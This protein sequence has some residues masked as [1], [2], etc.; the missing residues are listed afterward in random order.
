MLLKI[1]STGDKLHYFQKSLV[2]N[3][4]GPRKVLSTSA[5][6]GG[7]SE[8]LETVFNHD[9]NPGA[10]MACLMK[11]PTYE[12]HIKLL[13]LELGLDP[14]ES[15]GLETAASMDNVSIVQ[16]K[17]SS[18][19]V[20]AL[21]TGGVEVNGGRVGDPVCEEGYSLGTINIILLIDANLPSYTLTR[22]LVTATEAK[23]A[24]LQEL[25]A[26]SN[27][28]TGLA[29]G[30][31]TDGTI[32]ISNSQSSLICRNAGKHAK[33]GELIGIA[34]KRA[35]KEALYK[36]TGLSAQ[37]QHSVFARLKRYGLTEETVWNNFLAQGGTANKADFWEKISL[38]EEQDNLL[39]LVALLVH[40]WDQLEWNLLGD[41]EVLAIGQNL[42]G[43]IEE[44][45]G[46]EKDLV[47]PPG[48]VRDGLMAGLEITLVRWI[49]Y[50]L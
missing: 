38:L 50:Q 40:L 29:T 11:A 43:Q 36:Q 34:V 44:L 9:S 2:L 3:F 39:T 37:S 1:L 7:Y 20:T 14:K 33:L 49:K 10:G 22:A 4:V 42:L 41:K 13:A 15:T 48:K 21:V 18:L 45:L 30:S 35:V 25:M 5:L 26:G 6:N 16:E 19:V 23:T 46:L 28:S 17:Y 27:Y 12:E 31:G 32:I 47:L 24:A 8:D